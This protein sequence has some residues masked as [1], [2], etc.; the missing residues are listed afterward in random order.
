MEEAVVRTEE[1]HIHR[2]SKNGVQ[3][4]EGMTDITQ[5]ASHYSC[6]CFRARFPYFFLGAMS[7]GEVLRVSYVSTPGT[8][9]SWAMIVTNRSCKYVESGQ[10]TRSPS[11]SG[12]DFVSES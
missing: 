10:M 11:A 12:L 3:R 1:L 8:T 4:G 7:Y 9:S 5:A 2:A 6:V